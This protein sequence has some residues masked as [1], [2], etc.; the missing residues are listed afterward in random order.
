M[1]HLKIKAMKSWETQLQ[2]IIDEY[3]DGW[4]DPLDGDDVDNLC[5]IIKA[6]INLMEGNITQEEYNKILG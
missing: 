6:K 1:K 4:I 2:P 5:T 3:K